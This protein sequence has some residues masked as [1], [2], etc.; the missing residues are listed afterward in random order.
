MTLVFPNYITRIQLSN[1]RRKKYYLK[2]DDI[3]KKY[4][5]LQTFDKKG[6]LLDENGVPIVKNAKS[7]D[8][9]RFMVINGQAIWNGQI[10]RFSRAKVATVLHEYFIEN[11]EKQLTKKIEIPE[12][13]FIHW[14]FKFY[15]TEFAQDLT[16][17]H[18]LYRKTFEDAM[19]KTLN[20]IPDDNSKYVRGCS[21]FYI[22]SAEPRL[23]ISWEFI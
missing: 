7:C 17:H 9:P 1:K 3:P 16:N 5:H 22:Q 4:A 6:A 11:I 12:G 10:S 13:K 15:N 18:F 14:I 19:V 8:K 21:E 2:G 23:E 20:L